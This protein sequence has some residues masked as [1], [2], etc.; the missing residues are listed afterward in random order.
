MCI[1]VD[2][3]FMHADA[4]ISVLHSSASLCS[5]PN[6]A[7]HGLHIALPQ[8]PLDLLSLINHER[9]HHE[10]PKGREATINEQRFHDRIART[11]HS[12]RESQQAQAKD[13][14]KYLP[15]RSAIRRVGLRDAGLLRVRHHAHTVGRQI[16]RRKL[17]DSGQDRL[18]IGNI[19]LSHRAILRSLEKRYVPM[20]IHWMGL[21]LSQAYS[22]KEQFT[23]ESSHEID[24]LPVRQKERGEMLAPEFL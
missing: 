7:S 2:P 14:G 22:R 15:G 5:E 21:Y 12:G 4:E 17:K 13:Q 18:Q 24:F 8:S 1:I 16:S 10:A 9:P 3:K 19:V 20:Q 11:N 23:E 6:L